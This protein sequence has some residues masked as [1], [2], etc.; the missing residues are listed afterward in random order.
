MASHLDKPRTIVEK[1]GRDSQGM[2]LSQDGRWL[3]HSRYNHEGRDLMLVEET[4]IANGFS[5]VYV[6]ISRKDLDIPVVKAL[7]PGF[8]M[9]ADFD[10]YCRISHRLFNN[11]LKIHKQR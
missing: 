8:E 2:T 5:P 7:I 4:L 9:M 6:D 11:Y 1:K 3:L 10:K